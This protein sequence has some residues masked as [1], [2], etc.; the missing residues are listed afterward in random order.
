VEFKLELIERLVDAGLSAIE[1]C[2]IVSSKWVP[3]MTSGGRQG[4]LRREAHV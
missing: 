4:R 1:I 2:A 3:Q